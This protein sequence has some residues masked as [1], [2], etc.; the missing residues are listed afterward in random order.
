MLQSLVLLAC[1]VGMGL[2]M[3]FMSK[4][5]RKPAQTAPVRTVESLRAE[6]KRIDA[7]LRRREPELPTVDQAA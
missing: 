2:M 5:M 6:R 3:W 4:G 7:E 1:P